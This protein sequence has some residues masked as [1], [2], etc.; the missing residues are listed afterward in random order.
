MNT[1]IMDFLIVK[2]LIKCDVE[3]S[4]GTTK[5]LSCHTGGRWRMWRGIRTPLLAPQQAQNQAVA[6]LPTYSFE[7][8]LVMVFPTK[9]RCRN[10]S[11]FC[12]Q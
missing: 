9:M 11:V 2:M 8:A 3:A 5:S 6:L 1:D 4:C 7:V 12:V 10:F